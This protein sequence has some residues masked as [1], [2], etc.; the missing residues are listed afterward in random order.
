MAGPR[1]PFAA[2]ADPTRRAI[3]ELLAGEG[4]RPAGAIAAR[5]PA[6]SRVAVSKHLKV[7]REAGLV[8]VEPRGRESW[9]GLDPDA[10]HELQASFFARLIPVFEGSL[11]SLKEAV[12]GEAAR[13]LPRGKEPRRR[14]PPGPGV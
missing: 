7:L 14:G 11:R 13:A 10:I 6:I 1:D 3:L 9:Y 5:F 8:L 12:E 2:L 4:P